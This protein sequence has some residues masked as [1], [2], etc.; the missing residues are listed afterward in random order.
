MPESMV[1]E[2]KRAI[3]AQQYLQDC[4]R[5]MQHQAPNAK[6]GAVLHDLVLTEELN[7]VLLRSLAQN[8]S[9]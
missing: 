1:K 9:V 2:A 4:Y 6:L 5:R 7:E 8:L 3:A